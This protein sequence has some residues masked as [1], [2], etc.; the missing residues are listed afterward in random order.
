MK[1]LIFFFVLISCIGCKNEIPVILEQRAADFELL[2]P[3]CEI[4]FQKQKGI[5]G[6]FKILCNVKQTT[7]SNVAE[8]ASSA[9]HYMELLENEITQ[10]YKN[11]IKLSVDFP[12]KK[13]YTTPDQSS[14]GI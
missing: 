13:E 12:D 11:S 7:F 1:Y 2:H 3:E 6:T 8:E 4:I 10:E 9:L 5:K 14:K